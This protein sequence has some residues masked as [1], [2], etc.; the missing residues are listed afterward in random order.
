MNVLI[1]GINGLIGRA[2]AKELVKHHTVLGLVR[3]EELNPID[4][5]E[6]FT[7]D[8]S[9]SKSYKILEG[10]EINAIVHCA[11]SLNKNPL[12]EDIITSNCLGVR[13]MAFLA[14]EKKVSSFVYISGTHIIGKPINVPITEDHP[15]K[16]LISY[17]SSKLFGEHYLENVLKDVCLT[18]LRVSSPVGDE[19]SGGKILTVFIK[20]CLADQTITLAGKGERVQNYIDVK[21]VGESVLLSL[22]KK[23]AGVFN[24][25]GEESISNIE[26]ANLIIE[27]TNS[28]TEIVFSGE[29]PQE[30]DKWIIAIEKAK[31][32]LGFKPKVSM[33]DTISAIVKRYKDEG[34]FYK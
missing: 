19:L 25:A 31:S 32:E 30:E 5:V 1:T 11:A 2:I 10:K 12:A 22:E 28:K 18:T 23:I 29:D 17:H 15:A 34:S 4:S 9:D 8:I 13:N 20:N 16:P 7:G 3:T 33:K 6:Y 27:L 14:L 24:I 26:L 21:D